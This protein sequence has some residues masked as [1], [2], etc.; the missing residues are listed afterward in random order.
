MDWIPYTKPIKGRLI[1]GDP[2]AP[3]TR[4]WN[5]SRM[6]WRKIAVFRVSEYQNGYH[7]G[8]RTGFGDSKVTRTE[9]HDPTFAMRVG[10]EACTFF[11]VTSPL[12]SELELEL[13]LETTFF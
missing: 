12:G 3:P 1:A 2:C 6:R 7:I 9:I 4:W 5:L 8:F 10:Q 13:V 11:A